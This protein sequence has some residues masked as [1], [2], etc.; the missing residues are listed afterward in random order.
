MVKSLGKVTQGK[1]L[2][3]D[4]NDVIIIALLEIS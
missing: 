1:L 2:I 4:A 3:A